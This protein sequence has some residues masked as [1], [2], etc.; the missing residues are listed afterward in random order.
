MAAAGRDTPKAAS[1]MLL[2]D[3]RMEHGTEQ[4]RAADGCA[5]TPGRAQALYITEAQ[6]ETYLAEFAQVP[7]QLF[8]PGSLLEDVELETP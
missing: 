1:L 2:T 4:L 3:G 8:E 6:Q 7:V 5:A